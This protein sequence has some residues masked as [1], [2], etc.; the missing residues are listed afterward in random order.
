MRHEL[1]LGGTVTILPPAVSSIIKYLARREVLAALLSSFENNETQSAAPQ[2]RA[3]ILPSIIG[4][5]KGCL[6]F[7]VHSPDS[8]GR[9]PTGILNR[10]EMSDLIH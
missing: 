2:T 4:G 5:P 6:C 1:E 3:R 9:V 10:I 8:H 7:S